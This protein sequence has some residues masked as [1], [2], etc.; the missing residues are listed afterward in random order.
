M[1]NPSTMSK[2]T[3]SYEMI[4]DDYDS[5]AKE[6]EHMFVDMSQSLSAS[7]RLRVQQKTQE[8][9][10]Q[11]ERRRQDREIRRRHNQTAQLNGDN[12]YENDPPTS[13]TST[14][15]YS[16]QPDLSSAGNNEW[17]PTPRRPME[18]NFTTIL[19]NVPLQ[20]RLRVYKN[21]MARSQTFNNRRDLSTAEQN[22]LTFNRPLSEDRITDQLRNPEG[23][24]REAI[25][26]VT[27]DDWERK[28]SGMSLLQRLIAQYPDIITQNLHQIVLV[29]IQE[30]K[31]LRSQ[32]ARFALSTFCDMFKHLQRNMDIELD[33]TIKAIMQKSAES[34]EF[35]R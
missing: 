10:E 25:E 5:D 17:P 35:F 16:S 29:L 21:S 3:D 30:V 18:S 8:K 31:N 20:Q 4:T 7:F 14:S 28:C 12:S 13:S 1:Q 24:Y 32:V 23:V 19:P 2:R 26:S 9:I 27:N 15:R 33:L 6:N 11:K 34:N 22:R